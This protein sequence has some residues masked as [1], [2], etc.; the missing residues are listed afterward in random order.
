M[1][2]DWGPHSRDAWTQTHGEGLCEGGGRG[3]VR[4]FKVQGDQQPPGA[5]RQW[6]RGKEVVPGQEPVW[7]P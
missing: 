5:G 1:K 2:Q 6:G 3:G 4:P 7:D